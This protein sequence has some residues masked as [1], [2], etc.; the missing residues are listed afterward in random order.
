ML[1]ETEETLV[2]DKNNF[3]YGICDFIFKNSLFGSDTLLTNWFVLKILGKESIDIKIENTYLG[4]DYISG[5]AKVADIV[6]SVNDNYIYNIEVNSSSNDIIDMK[7]FCYIAHLYSNLPKKSNRYPVEKKVNQICITRGMA[8]DKFK[9]ELVESKI[10]TTNH[11]EYLQNIRF[12]TY[13]VEKILKYWYDG[14]ELRI[15]KYFFIIMLALNEYDLLKLAENKYLSANDREMLLRFRKAVLKLNKSNEFTEWL[16]Y[17]EQRELLNNS[18]AYEHGKVEGIEQGIEKGIEQNKLEN[19]KT[20]LQDGLLPEIIAKYVKLP[21]N[22]IIELK[23]N[24]T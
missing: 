5:K 4:A 9:D 11:E 19:A 17:E 20:M 15:H 7:N 14:D 6:I 22:I 24:L 8:K 2:H 10:M 23:N 12:F 18:Y 21:L 13:D 3:Y 1:T 16:T